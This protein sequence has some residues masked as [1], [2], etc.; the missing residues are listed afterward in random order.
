MHNDKKKKGFFHFYAQPVPQKDLFCT[1]GV[2]AAIDSN[3][4]LFLVSNGGGPVNDTVE[5]SLTILFGLCLLPL[6]DIF[7]GFFDW[8]S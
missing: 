4:T 8:L 6:L 2:S 7:S 1:L 3:A 5:N